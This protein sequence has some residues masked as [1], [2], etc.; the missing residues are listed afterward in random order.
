[1]AA[2]FALAAP[3]SAAQ[4]MTCGFVATVYPTVPFVLVGENE[5]RTDTPIHAERDRL[6]RQLP[7]L[8]VRDRHAVDGRR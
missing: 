3:A 2:C 8:R 1:V 4:Q 7:V 6:D 5:M